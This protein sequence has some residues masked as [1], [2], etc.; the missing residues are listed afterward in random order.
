MAGQVREPAWEPDEEDAAFREQ[1]SSRYHVW[2]KGA[3]VRAKDEVD[4]ATTWPL[5]PGEKR[6]WLRAALRTTYGDDHVWN[7]RLADA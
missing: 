3:Q 4:L 5:L 1:V 2:S 7:E 6:R